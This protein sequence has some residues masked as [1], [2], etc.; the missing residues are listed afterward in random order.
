MSQD[1]AKPQAPAAALTPEELKILREA[2]HYV[3]VPDYE[4]FLATIAQRDELIR[5]LDKRNFELNCFGRDRVEENA[6]QAERIDAVL[7]LTRAWKASGIGVASGWHEGRA[8]AAYEIDAALEPP[9]AEP[10]KDVSERD[11]CVANLSGAEAD[12]SPQQRKQGC[13]GCGGIIGDLCPECAEPL[14]ESG[15][16]PECNCVCPGGEPRERVTDAMVDAFCESF[17]QDAPEGHGPKGLQVLVLE[18]GIKWFQRQK[19]AVR[20]ALEAALS[21]GGKG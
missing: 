10:R 7:R 17:W 13:T 4:R 8:R 15:H 12:T 19:V 3:D 1:S 18:L 2:T 5:K 20:K 11:L 6:A 16:E 14:V 9:D 21:D